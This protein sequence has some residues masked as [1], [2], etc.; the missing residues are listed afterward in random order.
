MMPRKRQM[1]CEAFPTK[2][3]RRARS[4]SGTWQGAALTEG[5]VSCA[6]LGEFSG[7]VL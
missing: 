7:V 5:H 3:V 6:S 2:C 1:A 4:V